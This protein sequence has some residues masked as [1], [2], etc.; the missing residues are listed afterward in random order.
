MS[1]MGGGSELQIYV[2]NVDGSDIRQLTT[3]AANH[4]DPVWSPDGARIT[5]GSD[6][7]G[8]G[9]LNVFVM[10]ADG[11]GQQAL[12][13]FAP[14]YEAGDTNWSSDGEKIAFQ[15]DIDGMKQSDPDAH[16]E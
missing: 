5:F 15:Y 10:N 16:A 8:G 3:V 13:H 2:M 9:K 11:S 1:L 4:G 14:P 6:R 7:E 12:T